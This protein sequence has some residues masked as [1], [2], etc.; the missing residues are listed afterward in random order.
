[1]GPMGLMGPMDE[2]HGFWG[3]DEANMSAL[4]KNAVDAP[5]EGTSF[6]ARC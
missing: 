4:G 6:P 2:R 1:M 5:D 3:G